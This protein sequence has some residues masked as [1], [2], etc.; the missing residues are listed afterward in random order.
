[1]LR[2]HAE[3]GRPNQV[4]RER[5]TEKTLEKKNM[6]NNLTFATKTTKNHEILSRH[7]LGWNSAIPKQLH[8]D[9]LSIKYGHQT[10]ISRRKY[11][12]RDDTN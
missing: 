5:E 1:M 3:R 11:A 8:K 2:L 7:L 12:I 6:C 4:E 9:A 10:N